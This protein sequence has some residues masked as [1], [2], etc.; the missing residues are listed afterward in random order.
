MT[1][2]A[3]GQPLGEIDV[4]RTGLRYLAWY[5][6]A[7]AEGPPA[8]PPKDG[9][10]PPG[11]D[12]PKDPPKDEP[13]FTQADVNR[14]ID[15]RLARERR[16]TEE[17][18]KK[19]ADEAEAKRLTEQNEFKALADQK[20]KRV[21]ELE[22][23]AAERGRQARE[24]AIRYETRLIAQQ[25]G[26]RDPADAAALM[27]RTGLDDLPED[28]LAPTIKQRLEAVLQDKDYLKAAAPG[29]TGVP[30]TPR[31]N[32]TS[33]SYEQRVEAQVEELK[34]KRGAIL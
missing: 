21:E 27:D 9:D 29:T 4:H 3:G 20:A 14:M 11:G 6:I 31:A 5:P 12:P 16:R 8:D 7:G 24:T 15:D 33:P 19:A 34:T 26:F 22:R 18:Q 25:L 28:Q 17:A 2:T 1:P 32:G 10:P 13:R 23:E 30:P